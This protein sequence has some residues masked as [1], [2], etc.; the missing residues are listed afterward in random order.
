MKN[1]KVDRVPQTIAIKS[2]FARNRYIKN[3]CHMYN[4]MRQIPPDCRDCSMVNYG[5]DCHNNVVGFRDFE[6]NQEFVRTREELFL[7]R[8]KR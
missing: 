8:F 7:L 1:K 5:R 6:A 3:Y 2:R 4:D